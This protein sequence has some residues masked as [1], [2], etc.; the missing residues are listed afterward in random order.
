MVVG[1]GYSGH[2]LASR[3]RAEGFDVI[4][5]GRV[6]DPPLGKIALDLDGPLAPLAGDISHVAYLV[7]PASGAPEPRLSRLLQALPG[8]VSR[9]VLASTSGVYGDCQGRVI[10]ES[11]P[12]KPGSERAQR[13]VV[14]EKTLQ[15]WCESR[16][17]PAAILRIAGIYGPG[18]LPTE[19]IAAAEPII[20]RRD[21]Y[22]GNRI[23]RDDLVESLYQALFQPAAAGIYN[24]ADG[25]HASGSE[26]YRLVAEAAGLPMPPEIRR[27]EAL[28]SFS[29]QRL[30][31]LSESR[32]LDNRR[33]REELGVRLKYARL[34]EGISA[35]LTESTQE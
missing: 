16:K 30:S 33:L 26:F 28:E 24:V 3:L 15:D 7:P 25:E 2:A 1:A 11:E 21:A 19:R 8:N 13:R 5:S 4:A 20:D 35:S 17:I 14:Q 6:D 18:R 10:S 23:H 29:A 22:P 9:I 34:A 31:F 32:R 27:S 12:V